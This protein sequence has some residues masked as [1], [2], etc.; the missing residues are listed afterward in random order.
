MI[1]DFATRLL[2]EVGLCFAYLLFTRDFLALLVA[3]LERMMDQMTAIMVNPRENLRRLR[4]M[5]QPRPAPR[6]SWKAWIFCS[7]VL[8]FRS[9]VCR[10]C[11]LFRSTEDV[12]N[13]E[14]EKRD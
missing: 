5:Q 6:A 12:P 8:L 2:G 11:R 1:Q 10:W 9:A 14:G 7:C 4:E 13:L 3:P